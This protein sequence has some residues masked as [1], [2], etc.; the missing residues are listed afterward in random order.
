MILLMIST[1]YSTTE[2]KQA[3]AINLKKWTYFLIQ[4]SGFLKLNHFSQYT[5]ITPIR[6]NCSQECITIEWNTTIEMGL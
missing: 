6:R 4:A 3:D 5:S 1:I 2:G